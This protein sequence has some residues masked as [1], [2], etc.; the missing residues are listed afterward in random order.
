MKGHLKHWVAMQGDADR[1]LSF[2][3]KE[4]AQLKSSVKFT[5]PK[6]RNYEYQFTLKPMVDGHF[7]FS[8]EGIFGDDRSFQSFK[9]NTEASECIFPQIHPNKNDW[10]KK[11]HES[12]VDVQHWLSMFMYDSIE[13][14]KI[15]HFNDTSETA[16]VKR[17]GA[18]HDNAY[19]RSDASN[20][21]A[22]LYKLSQKHPDIYQQIR[23]TIQ[24]ALPFFDDFTLE[25]AIKTLPTEE[26]LIN[27]QWR[28]KNSDYPFWPSQLSDGSLRFIYLVTAL[29]QPDPPAI[30][31]IDEPE[32]GLHPYALSLLASLLDSA[33]QNMQIIVATQSVSL[34]DEF[35]ADDLIVVEYN[36]EG[37]QFKK[38]S[39]ESLKY[40]LE[41]YSLGE[42]WQKNVLGGR[43]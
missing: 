7:V 13:T 4:T 24:L 26:H 11:M 20:L 22:Y 34:V 35:S 29:L 8:E 36:K 32:L 12:P 42:L 2:G 38:L 43:P 14:L 17:R 28:Q 21:A 41:D 1:I 37:T 40:W 33:A 5:D 25:S 15:F 27:L 31:I 30:L 10:G 19:L 9:F 6:Q 16:S 39:A 23:E 3:I 18:L